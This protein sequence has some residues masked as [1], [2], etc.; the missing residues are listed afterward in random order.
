MT[1]FHCNYVSHPDQLDLPYVSPVRA[2]DLSGLPE[3]LILLP[4]ADPLRDEGLLYAKRLKEAGVSAEAK[5][6]A[7]MIHGFWQFGTLFQ[8]ASTATNDAARALR[9]AFSM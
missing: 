4:E 6:Y 5:V 2:P 1:W 7:G 3:A 9:S 8:E